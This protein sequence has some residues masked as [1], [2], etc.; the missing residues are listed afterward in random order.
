MLLHSWGNG[1]QFIVAV[2]ALNLVVAITA[3]N[4]GAENIEEQKQIFHML[5]QYILPAVR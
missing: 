4:Y 5:H 2:P 1:G 3:A